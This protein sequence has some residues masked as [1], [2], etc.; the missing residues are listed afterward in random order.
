MLWSCSACLYDKLC[1]GIEEEYIVVS[2][3]RLHTSFL[4]VFDDC[5]TK[6]SVCVERTNVLGDGCRMSCDCEY[7]GKW[8]GVLSISLY[9][10]YCA[11][12]VMDI[13][14]IRHMINGHFDLNRRLQRLFALGDAEE[15]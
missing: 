3:V 10:Y 1:G 11:E 4:H 6:C 14:P 5:R 7:N 12:D 8:V 15:R 9:M 2:R 13:V